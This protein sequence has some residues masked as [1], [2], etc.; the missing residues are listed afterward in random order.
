MCH[1]FDEEINVSCY[2]EMQNNAKKNKIKTI[3]SFSFLLVNYW[4][5]LYP[6]VLYLY[7]ALKRFQYLHFHCILYVH[8]HGPEAKM[9]SCHMFNPCSLPLMFVLYSVLEYYIFPVVI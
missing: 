7:F 6:I 1:M 5:V 4:T 3:H 2:S 9:S 8:S